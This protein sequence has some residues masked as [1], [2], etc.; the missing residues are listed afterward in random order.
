MKNRKI[1]YLH[2]TY[3]YE[4]LDYSPHSGKAI[5]KVDD[6]TGRGTRYT[7]NNANNQETTQKENFLI[8]KELSDT[9]YRI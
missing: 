8:Q 2:T 4:N 3:R 6:T 9:L 1:S 7:P 5:K